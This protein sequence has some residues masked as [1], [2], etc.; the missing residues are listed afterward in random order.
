MFSKSQKS[1]FKKVI[2]LLSSLNSTKVS[3]SD[4]DEIL[5]YTKDI[6]KITYQLE[7]DIKTN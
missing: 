1:I 6:Q 5:S 7:K 2:E 3:D 4:K